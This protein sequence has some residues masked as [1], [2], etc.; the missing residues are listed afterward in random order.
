MKAEDQ[1]RLQQLAGNLPP[2]IRLRLALTRHDLSD[3]FH[4]YG[5]QLH[6]ALPDIDLVSAVHNEAAPPGWKPRRA[7]ASTP[8]RKATSSTV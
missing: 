3:R 8:C 2:N 6:E 7:S 4:A 5:R 1:V